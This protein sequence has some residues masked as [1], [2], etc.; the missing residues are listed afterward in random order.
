MMKS[1][2]A[3]NEHMLKHK[4]KLFL[5]HFLVFFLL[6][7][8]TTLFFGFT[9]RSWENNFFV[10]PYTYSHD[11]LESLKIIKHIAEG[12]SFWATN[13]SL[14]YPF[15]S[16][17]FVQYPTADSFTI[18]VIK[19]LTYV[20]KNHFLIFNLHVLSTYILTSLVSFYV[21]LALGIK[22]KTAFV[23]SLFFSFLPYHQIRVAVGHFFLIQY[24]SVG[25]TVAIALA[26]LGFRGGFFKIIFEK[27]K[28]LILTI[29]LSLL[30][31]STAGGVYYASFS[32]II[33]TIASFIKLIQE[34]NWK[35][36][37]HWLG[38]CSIVIL[39]VTVQLLPFFSWQL[40]QNG[41]IVF[42]FRD[43]QEIEANGLR[44][45]R[46]LMPL[47]YTTYSLGNDWLLKYYSGVQHEQF[48]FIGFASIV[49]LIYCFSWFF[50]KRNNNKK[51][52]FNLLSFLIIGIVVVASSGGFGLIIGTTL[53]GVIRAYGR[54][55]I[56]IAFIGIYCAAVF[57]DE[58]SQ[59]LTTKKTTNQYLYI[60]AMIIV[61]F[62]MHYQLRI[63]Q[64]LY[65][66]DYVKE[67]FASDEELLNRVSLALPHGTKIFQIPIVEYPGAIGGCK[68]DSYDLLKPY[69]HSKGFYWS[70]GSL[71]Y[72]DGYQWQKSLDLSNV[73]SLIKQIAAKGFSAIYID[74]RGCEDFSQLKSEIVNMTSGDLYMSKDGG[75]MFIDF[76]KYVYNFNQ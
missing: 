33:W 35:V 27:R 67:Q 54:I 12:E 16:N 56:Y 10:Y 15:G 53:T 7:I 55:S 32:L 76:Q 29:L 19:L 11:G 61:A 64:P 14:G 22:K 73:T 57:W 3:L 5:N 63:S 46:L 51:I 65:F 39:L 59:K 47:P 8:V 71:T 70:F 6:I 20:S 74:N 50:K 75:T 37:I 40:S 43:L 21:L 52:F 49:G 9:Y 25:I 28:L 18:A 66:P 38:L 2:F 72:S 34:K 48:Q 31:I 68:F 17:I 23:G 60:L 42:P 26:I 44:L 58:F 30:A 36:L 41:Q 13:N 4:L 45:N 1:L 24:Y 62:F 69:L